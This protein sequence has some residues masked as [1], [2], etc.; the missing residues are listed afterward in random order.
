MDQIY[1][2]HLRAIT[3]HVGKPMDCG[4]SPNDLFWL[5]QELQRAVPRGLQTLLD[6]AE[7]DS[8]EWHALNMA[9]ESVRETLGVEE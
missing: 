6:Q 3:Q 2:M 8:P 1:K 4:V 7:L 9:L 5:V